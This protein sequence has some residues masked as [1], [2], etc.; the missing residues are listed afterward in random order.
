MSAPHETHQQ[1]G[2]QIQNLPIL[3]GRAGHL[4]R[5]KADLIVRLADT[6]A[7]AASHHR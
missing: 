6:P 7:D 5:W 4:P 1:P 3:N 2:P